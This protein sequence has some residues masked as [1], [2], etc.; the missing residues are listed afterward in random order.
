MPDLYEKNSRKILLHFQIFKTVLIEIL[1]VYNFSIWGFYRKILMSKANKHRVCLLHFKVHANLKTDPKSK[2]RLPDTTQLWKKNWLS[3]TPHL[4]NFSCAYKRFKSLPTIKT[5]WAKLF[6]NISWWNFHHVSNF[7][8]HFK[9]NFQSLSVRSI[10][11]LEKI[12]KA[13]GKREFFIIHSHLL[14]IYVHCVLLICHQKKWKNVFSSSIF[15]Y[16]KKE[17]NNEKKGKMK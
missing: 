9:H 11:K 17:E 3:G 2:I 8:F 13:R 16:F 7:V 5:T 10:K 14:C 15:L 4:S 6:R 1:V 12:N